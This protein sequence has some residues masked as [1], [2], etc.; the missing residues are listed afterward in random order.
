MPAQLGELDRPCLCVA[1]TSIPFTTSVVLDLLRKRCQSVAKHLKLASPSF[2]IQ[3]DVTTSSHFKFIIWEF[4]LGV[5]LF[6]D[7]LSIPPPPKNE[8]SP[9]VEQI[10]MPNLDLFG[11][12]P[13]PAD[14]PGFVQSRE[15]IKDAKSTGSLVGRCR[16]SIYGDSTPETI[17]I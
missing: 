8:A 9:K 3:V 5:P 4:I 14:R 13:S 15:K 16:P 12:P 2:E 10:S 17:S 7:L 6:L 1:N 11:K